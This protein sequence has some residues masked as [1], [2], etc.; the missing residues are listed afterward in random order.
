MKVLFYLTVSIYESPPP[1]H[2]PSPGIIH[3]TKP[4][5]LLSNGARW[6]SSSGSFSQHHQDKGN[7]QHQFTCVILGGVLWTWIPSLRDAFSETI[8][9]T[10]GW[11]TQKPSGKDWKKNSLSG[12][13]FRFSGSLYALNSVFS[14]VGAWRS[15]PRLWEEPLLVLLL[16]CV[17]HPEPQKL[18]LHNLVIVE[19]KGEVLNG[20]K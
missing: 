8:K 16:G 15:P 9:G 5:N 7:E 12:L 10:C 1:H 13:L 20:R 3:H 6:W 11:Q 19:L 14:R 4:G 18:F 17:A 2:P